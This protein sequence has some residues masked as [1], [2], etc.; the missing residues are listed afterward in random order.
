MSSSL[1]VQVDEIRAVKNHPNGDFLDIITIK[2]WETIVKRDQYKVGDVVVYIPT[3]VILPLEMVEKLGI[4]NYLAGKQKNRVK[5]AKLRGEMSY[6]L[7]IPNEGNWEAGTDVAEHYGIVKYE[8]PVRAMAGD[9]APEDSTFQRYTDVENINNYP[10]IFKEGEMVVATEKIDGSND[11]IGFEIH[12]P[13][14]TGHVHVEIKAGSNKLKRKKP[15]GDE[16]ASN[17]YWYVYTLDS[18]KEMLEHLA[19]DAGTKKT[20]ILYGEVYG[21][22]RGGHKSLHYGHPGT[23]NFVA[24]D[25]KI[26]GKYVS[27]NYFKQICDTYGIPYVPVV[28]IFEWNVEKARS[29]AT[30]DSLLAAKNGAK[31]MREGIVLCSLEERDEVDISRAVLKML[32]PDYLLLKNKSYEKGEATDFTDV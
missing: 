29:L 8:P 18:V 17:I 31:H 1:I 19:E 23:L 16:M 9:A 6:G 13:D 7:V 21:R 24:F 14:D 30:G 27:W 20:A 26:D 22:V 3:D 12:E 28:E 32:N 4:A 10:D 11:R 5:C 25:L 15:T 2:G